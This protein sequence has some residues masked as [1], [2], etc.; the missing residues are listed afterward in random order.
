TYVK[1]AS[2]LGML[3]SWLGPDAMRDGIRAYI[4]AHPNGSATAADLFQ[5]LSKASNKDAWAVAS[6]FLDQP[7]VP[8]VRA[9]LTCERGKRAEVHL[10]Q[11]RY[12]AR[13][14][15]EA[16]QKDAVWKIPICIAQE[17]SVGSS[18]CVVLDGPSTDVPLGS[19]RCP[20]W[21][22]PNADEN[23][24]YRFALPP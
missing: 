6:T 8:L 9:D 11:R 15:T 12:R 10:P 22:Y 19:G 1:G 7:G 18:V 4:K 23:G 5:A 17:G 24:Y 3:E 13:R 21:I 20:R 2:I 16:E 14:S